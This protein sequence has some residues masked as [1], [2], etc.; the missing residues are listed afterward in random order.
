MNLFAGNGFLRGQAV[1][2]LANAVYDHAPHAVRALEQVVV[3]AFQPGLPGEVAGAE[4]A[5]ARFNLLLADFTH[6]TRGMSE[7]ASWAVPPP[8]D[9][10]HF[11]NRNV[12]AMRFDEVNI[13]PRGVR[14]DNDRL[15]F[16]E[17]LRIVELVAQIINWDSQAVG[18]ARE[19]FFHLSR[20]IAK[21]EDAK[22]RAIVHQ[23]AAVAVQ[24]ATAWR[25]HGNVT[26]A[27]ALGQRA[28]LIGVDDLKLPEAKQQHAD[29]AHDDVGGHGQP[30]LRQS[31]VVAEPV[32]HENPAREY[33]FSGLLAR[34]GPIDETGRTKLASRKNPQR[35]FRVDPE[36]EQGLA[37]NVRRKFPRTWDRKNLPERP[38]HRRTKAA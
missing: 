31:I 2:F 36:N 11:Q 29:H 9:G 10:N 35:G 28:I 30:S 18:N 16:R 26:H 24:H 34:S 14:L 4:L 12:R 8:R 38:N 25:N 1:H 3:L 5:I 22:R 15:E 7:E 21:E 33:F 19:M 37:E 6:V 27:I 23:H 32:R 13:R 20:I 17:I